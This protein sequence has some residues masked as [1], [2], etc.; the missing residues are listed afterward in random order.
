MSCTSNRKCVLL[1]R[2]QDGKTGE[3][4]SAICNLRPDVSRALVSS[5][6]LLC[7]T[8]AFLPN[9]D[10]PRYHFSSIHFH[11]LWK[12]F[13]P[14]CSGKL[15]KNQ[16]YGRFTRVQ[17]TWNKEAKIDVMDTNII[18]SIKAKKIL[19]SLAPATPLPHPIELRRNSFL[20]CLLSASFSFPSGFSSQFSNH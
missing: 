14:H 19:L 2:S 17:K 6:L 1:Q 9:V 5:S 8:N 13:W 12:I 11:L 18:K 10:L 4:F 16:L 20:C 3:G 7:P 15:S